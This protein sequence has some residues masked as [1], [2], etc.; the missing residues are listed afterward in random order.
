MFIAFCADFERD[1]PSS[2]ET[3]SSAAMP[4]GIQTIS[5]KI[6]RYMADKFDE[7]SVIP[8]QL[9]LWRSRGQSRSAI[10]EKFD[11]DDSDWEIATRIINY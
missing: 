11:F 1:N 7:D 10:F 3:F 2:D 6:S 4:S 9:A 8:I 5:S